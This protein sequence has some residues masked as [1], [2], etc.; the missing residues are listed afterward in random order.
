MREMSPRVRGWLVHAVLAALAVAVLL[1]NLPIGRVPSEDEGVF[2]YVA[3]TITQGG[4]PYRDVW[5][6]KPP[7]IYLIDVVALLLGGQWGIWVTQAVALAAAAWLSYHA[8]SRLGRL[9][10]FFGTAAWLYAVPRL[11]LEQGLQTNF[12][13]LYALPLQFAALYLFAQ[14]AGAPRLWRA[15]TIGALAAAAALLKPTVVGIW[16]AI[17][18]W[19]V[20]SRG[21]TARWRDVGAR[22]GI[23]VVTAAVVIGLAVTWLAAAGALS[24]AIDVAWGYNLIYSSFAAP[25]ARVSAVADGLRLVLPPGLAVLAALGWLVVLRGPRSPVVTVALIALPVE[26]VLASAG[27]GYH[28][29]FVSWLPAM[30]VLAAGLAARAEPLLG[31]RRSRMA[32]VAVSVVL[33]FYPALL[34]GRLLTV[35]VASPVTPAAEYLRANTRSDETVLV[36]GAR[37]E[38]LVLAERRAPT[39]F[40]YQYAPLATR[41]YGSAARVS[42][43]LAD[44]ERA[45]PALILDASAQSFETPPLDRAGFGAWSSTEPQYAWP[46]ET[47]RVIDFVE[48]R[49]ERAGTVP[50]IG[51]PVWRVRSR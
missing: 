3:R 33:A 26:L 32:I 24:A 11:V 44:L 39:R 28:Y 18:I 43:L 51:W 20:V 50:G 13:E 15:V 29:Y 49:Y 22:L 45:P 40:I 4:M 16:I 19:L 1:P 41:G 34:V 38:V 2:L 6:H 21:G 47:V 31:T 30:G 10:A 46:A 5:D 25:A 12:V 7:L 37:T 27:R 35:E 14:D 48:T 9:A 42:E 36:W 8:V 17:A 23:M